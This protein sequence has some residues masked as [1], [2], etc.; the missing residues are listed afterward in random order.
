VSISS[1]HP[2][3]KIWRAAQRLPLA[4]SGAA[5][6]FAE[7]PARGW[8]ALGRAVPRVGLWRAARVGTPERFDTAVAHDRY[9]EAVELVQTWPV[10][11]AGLEGAQLAL[12]R[13]GGALT[14]VSD[15]R[16][17]DARGRRAVRTARQELA[18][19]GSVLPVWAARQPVQ[20]PIGPVAD[21]HVVDP[22]RIV[23]V[24]TNSLPVVQAGSTIR[25]QRVARAMRD[26]GWDA[27]VVT[28]P[29]F[30]VFHGDISAADRVTFDSVPYRRLLPGVAPS[31]TRMLEVYPRLL[32]AVVAELQP[33]ILHGASD[34]VNTR[35][36]LEVGRRRGIPVAY[37]ART[38]FEETW[39]ATHGGDVARTT[40]TYHLLRARHDE[41][42]RAADA[43]TTLGEGMRQEIIL[44]GIPA[45]RIF[46][47]PN[48]VSEE[49]LELET[50]RE[51]ARRLL[52][53]DAG[54]LLVGSVATLY[55][56]EGFDTLVDAVALLRDQ[57]VDARILL[58]GDGP[59]R[60]S[61][62]FKAQALDV[63]LIS[64]GRVPFESV[65]PYFDA[66]D[67]CAVPR[68]D[69]PITRLVTALKP[70]EAQARGVPVV[71]SDV[72]AVAEVLAPGSVLVPA[73]DAQSWAQAL[74]RVAEPTVR[75]QMGDAAR[76][77]VRACRTWPSVMAT[78]ASAYASM[79]Y[80]AA[81]V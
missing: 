17:E 13:L 20:S 78:Y 34:H 29:G 43:I 42:L 19:L 63:P 72:P 24:V 3:P 56:Y 7:D 25:T 69:D 51:E 46:V 12:A 45:E 59:E 65:R 32:D 11:Q 28:R 30:P 64:P 73:G 5:R 71:G 10:G 70:L 21:E 14:E 60:Q 2:R 68:I 27:Q 18:T 81:D 44:R 47:V 55:S 6:R 61:L 8:A 57:G 76:E 79:G 31:A 16:T 26:I 66:L 49:F 15:A 22:L 4:V 41:I 58:V 53:I 62:V 33:H 54:E 37:E 67:V 52:G 9:A 23:H 35:A 39:A 40:D 75:A 77:W 50:G 48:A 38:F 36:A 80:E 74:I 1:A